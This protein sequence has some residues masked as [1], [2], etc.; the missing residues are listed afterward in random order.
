MKMDNKTLARLELAAEV[1]LALKEFVI[2]YNEINNKR[3]EG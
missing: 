1:L 2:K 3:L